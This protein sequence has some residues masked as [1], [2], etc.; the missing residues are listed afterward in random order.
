MDRIRPV[1]RLQPESCSESGCFQPVRF[2]YLFPLYHKKRSNASGSAQL[3]CPRYGRVTGKNRETS[4]L[5]SRS[6][7]D[8]G[9]P[10]RNRGRRLFDEKDR[11]TIPGNRASVFLSIS[12]L[13]R[14]E[15]SRCFGC[16]VFTL[17]HQTVR[18]YRESGKGESNPRGRL[19]GVRCLLRLPTPYRGSRYR[20]SW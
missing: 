12:A 17:C 15:R 6:G 5:R 8:G 14:R 1:R 16:G 18:R 4:N 7:A 11:W 9:V 20:P 10:D 2:F 13:V 19:R 3:S